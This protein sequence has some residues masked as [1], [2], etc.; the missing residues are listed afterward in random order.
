MGEKHGLGWV[1]V[2]AWTLVCAVWLIIVWTWSALHL[3]MPVDDTFYY[4][5]TALNVAHG[6]GSSF[7]GINSTDGYHPL[8]LAFL[9][10]LFKP[11]GD[12]MVLLT[13]IAFTAQ[14][15]MIWC[16]GMLLARLRDAGGTK[17]L[18]PLVLVLANPFAAKIVLCG[19]ETALQFLLSSGAL[20]LWWSLRESPRGYRRI[21]W[22]GL[23]AICALATLARLDTAF[24]GAAILAMPLMLPSELERKAGPAARLRTTALGMAVF[25]GLIG[26]FLVYRLAVFH[27]LMPVSGAI[28]Q[29]LDADEV[30]PRAARLAVLALAVAGIA[31]IWLAAKRRQARVLVLLAP[32]VAGALVVAIYNFAVRGEMSPNLIRIWYLEPYFL[33]GSLIAGAVL[34]IPGRRLP[35]AIFGA[36]S[37]LW[38]ALTVF[39]WLYRF[40]P[41]S[42]NLY[43]AA[44]RSSRWVDAH[45]EV[46]A[47]GAAWDA[48]FAAAF[49]R[50]PVMNLDGL[51][52]SWEY[53]EHY[54]DRGKVDEF[55]LTRQPADFVMQFA[56]PGTVRAIARRFEREPLPTAPRLQTTVTGG[57]DREALSGRWGVDLTSWTVARVEC[58]TASM[59]YDPTTTVGAA[60]YFVL[61]RAPLA[62]RMTLAEFA[63][64]NKGRSSC[65]GFTYV[66]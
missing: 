10:L 62:G 54:L 24:L 5:K 61:S 43:L 27:H 52:N 51:I 26:A 57:Q 7:D 66:E 12:D 31:G 32:A 1:P 36:A 39:S 4:F 30:A 41:R 21:E 16:G 22:A 64:A 59:A 20:A 13:R 53:K 2:A 3:A 23:A 28:K 60:Y 40:E 19:Q 33:V 14:V 6:H 35:V 55:I 58:V 50:K 56:W 44:E 48:G 18:W 47:I 17:I 63:L 45:A 34:A 46:G 25:C 29:H 37:G 49:T 38:L 42:Y 9:A 65:D 8:W 11:F 15:L